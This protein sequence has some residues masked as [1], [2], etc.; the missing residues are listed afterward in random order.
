MK[1]II[2]HIRNRLSY[3][4]ESVKNRYPCRIIKIENADNLTR[5]TTVTFRAV[6]KI[7]I[8]TINIKELIKDSVLIEKFHPT[9]CI[10]LGVAALGDI[11]LKNNSTSVE[12]IINQYKTISR[13]LFGQMEEKHE[14]K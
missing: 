4:F 9:E 6:T 7:N 3:S 8:R 14:T 5:N 13:N 11:L 1:H 12:E 2:N 10:K